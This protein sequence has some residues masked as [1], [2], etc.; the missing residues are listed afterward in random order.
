[1]LL[2]T[3]WIVW[4]LPIA[5]SLQVGSTP[6]SAGSFLGTF[7]QICRAYH[8]TLLIGPLSGALIN[9]S[10]V[11]VSSP[12]AT[13]VSAPVFEVLSLLPANMNAS[14]AYNWQSNQA[15][16]TP[17]SSSGTPSVSPTPS[18]SIAP[19]ASLSPPIP[20]QSQ[21]LSLT[22]LSGWPGGVASGTETAGLEIAA[23]K[24][25]DTIF[26]CRGY[27]RYGDLVPGKTHHPQWNFCDIPIRGIEFIDVVYEVL[28]PN[29]QLAWVPTVTNTSLLVSLPL[30]ALAVLGGYY[31][32]VNV[33]VCRAFHPTTKSGPHAGYSDGE[34]Y[35]GLPL[36]FFSYGGKIIRVSPFDTLVMLPLPSVSRTAT[37]SPSTSPSNSPTGTVSGTNTPSSTLSFGVTPTNTPSNLATQTQTQSPSSAL[38][39]DA[40]VSATPTSSFTP[41]SSQS[42]LE[43]ASSSVILLSATPT[44]GVDGAGLLS[45]SSSPSPTLGAAGDGNANANNGSAT[46]SPGDSTTIGVTVTVVLL[47]L[48]GAFYMYRQRPAASAFKMMDG[49]Q[50]VVAGGGGGGGG[51]TSGAIFVGASSSAAAAATTAAAQSTGGSM[52]SS[53][54]NTLVLTG[55][56]NEGVENTTNGSS[57]SNLPGATDTNSIVLINSE[58][59]PGEFKMENGDW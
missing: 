50:V 25:S 55:S 21:W 14:D 28:R 16:L 46:T 8:P 33:T 32:D 5:A 41:S 35:N 22:G 12:N 38:T 48:G 44:Q 42:P 40:T 23:A 9:S 49:K 57:S 34:L 39:P 43:S 53:A 15:G 59:T 17:P 4:S 24:M 19:S 31:D 6:I 13:A 26:V 30:G 27:T 47:A 11:I 52:A 54:N 51:E 56:I 58:P 3:P 20:G 7:P 45:A 29:P 37:T 1:V 10:C 18:T 2:R 36:C